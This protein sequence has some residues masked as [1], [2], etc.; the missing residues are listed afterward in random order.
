[1]PFLL[2]LEGG[3]GGVGQWRKMVKKMAKANSLFSIVKFAIFRQNFDFGISYLTDFRWPIVTKFERSLLAS[4]S[5]KRDP[6]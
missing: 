6:Y 4:M 5:N 2:E 3:G 1:M